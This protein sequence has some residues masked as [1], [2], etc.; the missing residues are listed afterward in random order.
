[1]PSDEEV[2]QRAGSLQAMT[3]FTAEA[4]TTLRPHVE[5]A[6]VADLQHRTIAGHPRPSRRYR[7][8]DHRP[9]P[10][11]AD[12]WLFLLTDGQQHPS[13]EV[14]GPRFGLSP[15]KAHTW[16]HRLQAGLHHA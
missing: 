8:S 12:Q 7:A 10:T 6:L 1:M 2:L 4:F 11:R 14:H 16:I 13:H 9:F 5:R 3:G 15:S